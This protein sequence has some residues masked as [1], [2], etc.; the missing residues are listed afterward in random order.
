MSD[1]NTTIK[2]IGLRLLLITSF[3][4]ILSIVID[5]VYRTTYELPFKLPENLWIKKEIPDKY[6]LVKVGN[7]HAFEGITFEGFKQKSID[8]SSTAQ[9]FEYDLAMLKMYSKQIKEDAVIVINISPI[10]FSQ[11]KPGREDS[12]QAQYF[13][14]RISPFLIPNLKVEDYLQS[15]ILTFLIAGHNLRNQYANDNKERVA[16]AEQG[17]TPT[18][19]PKKIMTKE[20]PIPQKTKAEKP[21]EPVFS[22]K[23]AVIHA[24]QID[25]ASLN[26][27]Y[28]HVEMINT[29]LASSSAKASKRLVD[30]MLFSFDRWYR[31][32][33]FDPKYFGSNRKD[34]EK[35]ISYTLK[36]KWKPVLI[37][38][39]ISAVMQE[40]LLDDYMQV[41]LYD[42]I[43]KTNLQGVPYFDF[44]SE[45]IITKN[46]FYYDAD[47]LNK[48]GAI[49]F[50]Y[51][52]LQKLIKEGYLP[53]STDGY[54]Y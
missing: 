9:S 5:Y 13:D 8:L 2:K 33:A 54:K 25:P 42:N 15:Q 31:T 22:L 48:N 43:K 4:I 51:L 28:F 20:I 29:K 35:L 7:S 36:K 21:V 30:S 40:G 23:D 19:K 47:H 24:D 41:Y 34:L 53:K 52:L 50:S 11:A 12:L 46:F 16:M 6:Q 3:V 49:T 32:K 1:F 45:P 27:D 17:I 14:G 39:P 44:S 38:V 37:T 26:P 18:P 10:S